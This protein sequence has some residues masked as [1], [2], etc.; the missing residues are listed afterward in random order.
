MKIEYCKK[1]T[2]NYTYIPAPPYETFL[3]IIMLRKTKKKEEIR[4]LCILQKELK[5]HFAYNASSIIT[6]FLIFFFG[7]GKIMQQI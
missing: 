2:L 1:I 6:H 4:S 3:I 5:A 7:Q